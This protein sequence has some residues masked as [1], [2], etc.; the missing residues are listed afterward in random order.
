MAHFGSA[1]AALR[2]YAA[3]GFNA[4]IMRCGSTGHRYLAVFPPGTFEPGK[5]HDTDCEC[6]VC[7]RLDSK[8]DR[9]VEI[10]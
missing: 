4:G 5:E 7:G 1:T 10:K 9:F 3:E 8:L 2:Y 6:G